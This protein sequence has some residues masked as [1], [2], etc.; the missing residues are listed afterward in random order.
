MCKLKIWLCNRY[1]PEY[2]RQA[3]VE[4]NA[5]LRSELLKVRRE[6]VELQSYV[7]GL[8]YGLRA[9]RRIVINNNARK[10]DDV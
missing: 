1:L 2:C 10:R 4:E 8:E 6:N 3:M 9:Q 7:D 5:R